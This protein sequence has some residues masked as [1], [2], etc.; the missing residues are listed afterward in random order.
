MSDKLRQCTSR[1]LLLWLLRL[2]KRKRI[3]GASM[4]P[5]LKS[6]D[7]VLVNHRAYRRKSPT[8]GDIV[9]ARHPQRP[10]FPIIKRITALS[11][12]DAYFLS[13]DNAAESTDSRSF[14]AIK[15]QAIIGHVI[16][17]FP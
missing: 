13:G 17:R 4:F 15:R 2:R 5:L 1:D 6:G 7:E 10:D 12:D 11:G 8:L 14:G 16:C 9:L 3:S